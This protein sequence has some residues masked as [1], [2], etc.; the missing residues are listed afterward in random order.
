MLGSSRFRMN[1]EA[2]ILSQADLHVVAMMLQLP[3]SPAALPLWSWSAK[4]TFS[5]Q[6]PATQ[7]V[8]WAELAELRC[9]SPSLMTTNLTMLLK[10][11]ELRLLEDL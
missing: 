1:M 9:A 8:F 6:M 4:L 10:R 5:V 2:L 3:N 11:L 7:E